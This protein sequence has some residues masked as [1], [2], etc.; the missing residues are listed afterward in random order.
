MS[1]F[2]DPFEIV[3]NEIFLKNWYVLI[4]VV[5]L[6]QNFRLISR[7]FNFC[8]RRISATFYI[9]D[10]NFLFFF[11]GIQIGSRREILKSYFQEDEKAGLYVL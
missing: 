9:F 10:I 8:L 5:S 2:V 4:V 11:F 6:K 1:G 7:N 3:V